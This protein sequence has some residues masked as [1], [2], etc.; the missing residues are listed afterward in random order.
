[1]SGFGEADH[2]VACEGLLATQAVPVVPRPLGWRVVRQAALAPVGDEEE[3]PQDVDRRAL[4]AVAQQRRD[5]HA[6]A[7]AQ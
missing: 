3:I 7:L 5:R 4:H 1:M 6:V 2:R